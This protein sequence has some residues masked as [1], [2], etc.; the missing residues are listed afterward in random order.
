MTATNN[1]D[2]AKL[3]GNKKKMHLH[4]R[5][6]G[7]IQRRVLADRPFD[8]SDPRLTRSKYRFYVWLCLLGGIVKGL[9]MVPFVLQL[10]KQ[11]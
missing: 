7:I 3:Q 10:L 2:D 9:V 1:T 5:A 8:L 6:K 11:K 4:K